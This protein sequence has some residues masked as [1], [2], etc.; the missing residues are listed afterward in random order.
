MSDNPEE[1]EG[2]RPSW[3]AVG[4]LFL[5]GFGVSFGVFPVFRG[6]GADLLARSPFPGLARYFA[7]P[8]PAGAPAA[9]IAASVDV[10][11]ATLEDLLAVFVRSSSNP[12][13]AEK[14]AQAIKHSEALRAAW[15]AFRKTR[16]R[17]GLLK[18]FESS[19]DFRRI[20]ARATSPRAESSAPRSR[21]WA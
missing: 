17:A 7:N 3:L 6:L 15:T 21:R 20:V 2:F 5:V 4:A 10:E 12:T 8:A 18:A 1:P 16:D 11:P 19:A 13:I 9:P 14:V